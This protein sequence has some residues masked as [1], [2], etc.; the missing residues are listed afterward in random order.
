MESQ[1][2]EVKPWSGITVEDLQRGPRRPRQLRARAAQHPQ[3]SRGPPL[4]AEIGP[5]DYPDSYTYPGGAELP[6][7]IKNQ[8]TGLRDPAAPADPAQV[9]WFCFTCSFRPW[10][11]SGDADDVEFTV[12]DGSATETVEG[13]AE[14]GRWVSDRALTAGE[15]AYVGPRLRAGRLRQ[16]QR[17]GLGG[18]GRRRA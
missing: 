11:D 13:H 3:R 1:P 7:F 17:R 9:E 18:G 10:I 2:F 8:P 15:A 16:L 4:A 12:T 5:I 6:R 14:G